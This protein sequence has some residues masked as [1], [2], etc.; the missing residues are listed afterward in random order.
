MPEGKGTYGKQVGRPKGKKRKVGHASKI[1]MDPKAS[2][3]AGEKEVL[4][5]YVQGLREA[6]KGESLSGEFSNTQKR[7]YGESDLYKV[8]E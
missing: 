8:G 2:K 5:K 3:K 1:E 7:V 4:K 6:G